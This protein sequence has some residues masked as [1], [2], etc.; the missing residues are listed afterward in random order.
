MATAPVGAKVG[1]RVP[2]FETLS[3]VA[4]KFFESL[5]NGIDI[6]LLE[7]VIKTKSY[8][9][10]WYVY[11]A[12]TVIRVSTLA[13]HVACEGARAVGL[14]WVW[15]VDRLELGVESY[16]VVRFHHPVVPLL[17]HAACGDIRSEQS[18][19]LNLQIWSVIAY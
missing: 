18:A 17:A 8:G 6:K 2:N 11:H 13:V 3:D 4:V 5:N 12:L 7:N 10:Q 14:G 1:T 16:A 15:S 19:F 9:T